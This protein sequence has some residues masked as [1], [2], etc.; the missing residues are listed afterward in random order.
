MLDRH[1]NSRRYRE[2]QMKIACAC[3]A[4][5]HDA[6]DGLPGKAH[7]VPDASLFPLMD[8]FDEILLTRCTTQ[9]EREAACTELRRLLIKAT[10]PAWQCAHCGRLYIDDATRQLNA[11]APESGA[12][13]SVFAAVRDGKSGGA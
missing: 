2:A 6:G 11:Y 5:I 10:R 4:T 8:A 7:I 3:G 12:A 1:P 13:T 9:G